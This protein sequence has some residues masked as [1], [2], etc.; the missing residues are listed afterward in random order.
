MKFIKLIF[1]S[2][3]FFIIISVGF[4]FL[5]RVNPQIE[6]I[7]DTQIIKEKPKLKFMEVLSGSYQLKYEKYFGTNFPLRNYLVNESNFI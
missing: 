4:L 3:F 1:V 6:L 7:G 5:L 2:I